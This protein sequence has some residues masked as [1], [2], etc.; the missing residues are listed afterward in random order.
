MDV[1]I[2]AF[3][4]VNKYASIEDWALDSDYHQRIS[5]E[6][7]DDDGF[8]VDLQGC[9]EGAIEASGFSP[10]I[11]T[12]WERVTLEWPAVVNDDGHVVK[13]GK[14]EVRHLFPSDGENGTENLEGKNDY[15]E[16]MN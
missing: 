4:A 11:G 5:G 13:V 2:Q 6:W 8:I 12:Y 15:W 16:V 1:T 10:T 7:V 14:H 3:L 9:I